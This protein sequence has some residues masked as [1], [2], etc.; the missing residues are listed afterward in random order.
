[1]SSENK[2][3][4]NFSP[5]TVIML[6]ILSIYVALLL[7]LLLWAVMQVFKHP[8]DFNK[9][10]IW[11]P[12]SEGTQHG[13]TTV[14]FGALFAYSEKTW[15]GDGATRTR[16]GFVEIILNSVVYAVGGALVNTAVMGLMAYLTAKY[17]YF[18]SKLIYGI[19]IVVMVV[20]I[21]GAQASEIQMLRYMH[22]YNTR[23][24]FIVLKASFVGGVYF[25]VFYAAFKS[26]PMTYTEAAMIDG[27]SDW[28]I[29][30]RICLPLVLNVFMTVFLITFIQYWNDYQLPLVYMPDYPT[31]SYYIFMMK[32]SSQPIRGDGLKFPINAAS[33]P[34]NLA[35]AMILIAPVLII[36][37]A[38]H[39]R[40]MGNLSVGGIKG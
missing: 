5:L 7:F 11:F 2:K 34:L 18:Y 35:A 15:M 24:A 32:M 22:L 8:L 38:L 19:V 21:V 37:I 26:I 30:V 25:L 14:N 29:V 16:V 39:E 23:F 36:F 33:E 40:L 4:D 17:E 6:V 13:F 20:P 27:A 28:C 3:R 12:S 10:P 1:M 31:L 9:N